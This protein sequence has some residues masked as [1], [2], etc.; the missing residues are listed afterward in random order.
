LKRNAAIDR[1]SKNFSGNL[2]GGRENYL[3][4]ERREI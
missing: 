4:S 3:I 2:W 1:F